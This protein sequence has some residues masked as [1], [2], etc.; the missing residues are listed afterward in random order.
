MRLLFLL[1]SFQLMAN[2]DPYYI[3]FG[4]LSIP[5]TPGR[6]NQ[7]SIDYNQ[8]IGSLDKD[9]RFYK[10]DKILDFEVAF[11]SKM[12]S[13]RRSGL[14]F[15]NFNLDYSKIPNEIIYQLRNNLLPGDGITIAL[16]LNTEE[17][18]FFSVDILSIDYFQNYLPEIFPADLDYSMV[19]SF[20]MVEESGSPVTIKLDTSNSATLNIYQ[21]YKEK[22]L[23]KVIHISQFQTHRRYLGKREKLFDS[24]S[25]RSV[26]SICDQFNPQY[27]PELTWLNAEKPELKWG[28]Y[29]LGKGF[30]LT[31][32]QL[33]DLKSLFYENL[34]LE[35]CDDLI[36]VQFEMIIVRPGFDPVSIIS[37]SVHET[38]VAKLFSTLQEGSSVYFKNLILIDQKGDPFLNPES[39][40]F[41][42]PFT[43][44]F[45]LDISINQCPE[46]SFSE[47]KVDQWIACGIGFESLMKEILN[48]SYCFLQ[49]EN[50]P[51]FDF[52]YQ[53]DM[54]KSK[55]VLLKKIQA[56]TGFYRDSISQSIHCLPK[57]PEVHSYAIR[58]YPE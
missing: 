36:L 52:T 13:S 21:M 49:C 44:D 17:F 26:F 48:P 42:I 56:I 23:Y 19:Y 18:S 10:R 14:W 34:F 47:N 16:R 24:K 40:S 7:I 38:R 35:N 58:S 50:M 30:N 43:P 55:D 53:G 46:I 8:L 11:L 51:H 5:I 54:E 12:G 20:Q 28:N 32:I 57:I 4:D 6:S 41:H 15:S 3:N 25:I 29:H 22:P 9:I 33:E 37:N 39:Y 27:L 1:I 31:Y 2:E 45:K